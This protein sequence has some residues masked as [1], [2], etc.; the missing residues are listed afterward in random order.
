MQTIRFDDAKTISLEVSGGTFSE[1][2]DAVR[3]FMAFLD[4]EPDVDFSSGFEQS[5][6]TVRCK[7]ALSD[8]WRIDFH[9]VWANPGADDQQ[10]NLVKLMNWIA[11][12]EDAA[13]GDVRELTAG[14]ARDRAVDRLL[15]L[16]R[17]F[18]QETEDRVRIISAVD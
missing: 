17:A 15:E 5:R 18:A 2:I 8:W 1:R 13:P 4:S 11:G 7:T 9:L 12:M 10:F 6:V 16:T 3:Q 14:V